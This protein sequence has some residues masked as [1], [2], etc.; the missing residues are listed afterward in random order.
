MDIP[1][2]IPRPINVCNISGD[3]M[4]NSKGYVAIVNPANDH[5][6][7]IA[8]TRYRIVQH[9]SALQTID[10]ALAKMDYP[11]NHGK[12]SIQ[13]WKDGARMQAVYKFTEKT[14]IIGNSAVSPT[15]VFR[16]SYDLSCDRQFMLGAFRFVCSNGLYI[17]VKALV[18]RSMHCQGVMEGMAERDIMRALANIDKLFGAYEH[19]NTIIIEPEAQ[20]ESIKALSL[21]D[22]DEKAIM[23][24]EEAG[25]HFSFIQHRPMMKWQMY[26]LFY[27]FTTHTK[28]SDNKRDQLE[29]K[30]AALPAFNIK[31]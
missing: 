12:K 27:Q 29:H 20:L 30:I 3:Q 1:R 21:C 15:L 7:T 18:N 5:I 25:K 14:V 23:V 22:K 6:Y 10:Q 13:V 24:L 26:N 4:Y 17:G 16:N 28:M 2:A 9:D 31:L 19:W 8:S 11:Y